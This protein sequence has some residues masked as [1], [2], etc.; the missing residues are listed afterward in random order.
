MLDKY[1]F[2]NLQQI[3][4]YRQNNLTKNLVKNISKMEKQIMKILNMM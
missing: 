2:M 4:I 3:S 1:F